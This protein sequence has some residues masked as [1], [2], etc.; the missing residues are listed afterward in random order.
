VAAPRR[1]ARFSLLP[2]RLALVLSLAL[3]GACGSG[4]HAVRARPER[5]F[6]PAAIVSRDGDTA[7][8]VAGGRYAAG[9][10]RRLV[11]GAH[12]RDLWAAPIRVPALNLATFAGGLTPLRQGGGRQTRSL[13]LQAGDGRQF[14]FRT[15]A[16]DQRH[17][18]P[19]VLRR[20]PIGDIFQDQA[21]AMNPAGAL[22]VD[23]LASAVGVYHP[24]PLLVLAPDDER[25]G[26]YRAAFAGRLGLLEEYPVAES[27]GPGGIAGVD[28]IVSTRTLLL[29]LDANSGARVDARAYLTARLLDL[30]VGD[31]DRHGEQWR[32]ARCRERGQEVYTPLPRDRDQAFVRL[33]GLFGRLAQLT[34]GQMVSF[35]PDFGNI[36]GLVRTGQELD[37]RLLAGLDRQTWEAVCGEMSARL[38]DA[39]ID[40]AV[41]RLPQPYYE[42]RGAW[43]AAAL[44]SRRDALAGA[45]RRWQ[46]LLSRSPQAGDGG[47]PGVAPAADPGGKER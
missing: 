7:T 25:L 39:V 20:T 38:T 19:R 1:P 27:G 14:V 13:R 3:C 42:L 23:E 37:R 4:A 35:S 15:V 16:K 6:P 34:S 30:L 24:R 28:A 43:L 47:R 11:A 33:D 18:L 12:Y 41:R 17:V 36:P 9:R 40:A 44:S 8:V 31:W 22:V 45:A 5:S 26:E 21:S 2:S 29:R 10:L 46:D 32:W